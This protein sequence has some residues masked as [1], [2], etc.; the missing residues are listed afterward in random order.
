MRAIRIFARNRYRCH[1][2]TATNS[3]SAASSN[4]E[5]VVPEPF[6]L[7]QHRLDGL[8]E[9]RAERDRTAGPECG[10]DCVVQKE[11]PQASSSL[12]GERRRHGSKAGNVLGED[13]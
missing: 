5:R 2:F 9:Y 12:T 4:D 7:E 1:H 8:V 10:S 13:Q 6:E 11:A 3:A